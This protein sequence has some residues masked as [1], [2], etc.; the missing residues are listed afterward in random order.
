MIANNEHA[1]DGFKPWH[2]ES[3][4]EGRLWIYCLRS[5]SRGAL[6]RVLGKIAVGGKLAG[7]EFEVFRAEDVTIETNR[8]K[9]KVSLDGEMFS[10]FAPLRYRSRPGQLHVLVPRGSKRVSESACPAEEVR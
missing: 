5:G 10:L 9:L 4:T 8:R 3:I 7:E 2:R 1:M 6:L